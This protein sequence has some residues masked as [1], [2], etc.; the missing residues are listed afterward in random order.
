M[1]TR[2]K[3]NDSKLET[4]ERF[5][6]SLRIR[7]TSIERVIKGTLKSKDLPQAIRTAA[8]QASYWLADDVP[9]YGQPL[10]ASISIRALK[11]KAVKSR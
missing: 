2:R 9:T 5:Q 3:T 6:L 4:R 10:R 11:P 7:F 8:D 1:A